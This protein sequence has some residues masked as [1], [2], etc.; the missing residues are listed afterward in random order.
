M[1]QSGSVFHQVITQLNYHSNTDE[2]FS[3][4]PQNISLPCSWLFLS[5]APT[6]K[7]ATALKR[8]KFR[9]TPEQQVM[10]QAEIQG[11]V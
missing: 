3:Y 8:G 1:Y 2:I 10:R 11:Q 9:M 5:E 6:V 7:L 4:D